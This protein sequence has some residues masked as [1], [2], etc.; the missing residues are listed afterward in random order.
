MTWVAVVLIGLGVADLV[1]TSL[2]RRRRLA[3]H[4]IGP[5]VV[6]AVALLSGV[7]GWAD[8]IA[9]LLALGG[10][11][12]WTELS[13]R[14]QTTGRPAIWAL[15]ALGGTLAGLLAFSG[16]TTRPNGP[17]ESWL[18]W[19]DLPGS[20]PPDSGRV[21]LLTGLVLFNLATAN[22]VVRLVLL[23]IGALRP[24]Q[25]TL[26]RQPQAAD[27]LKGGRLLGPMERLVI[28]GL[29]LAGEFGAA[30]LVIA[31]KG[32]LRFPE[33]QA[34]AR[35][36]AA[37]LRASGTAGSANPALPSGT[38]AGTRTGPAGID[39]VTEYFLV[40]SFVSWLLALGSLAVAR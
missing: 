14:A 3:A 22:I 31:A 27:R 39:D 28:L 32:L 29:G 36:S 12:L 9:L 24:D 6:L 17:L 15:T 18:G 33:I 1:R 34:S 23:A 11:A 5:V 10:C 16:A 35:G 2:S 4:L 25:L 30:G 21:L 26:P 38:T 19:A 7:S 37:S 40:G 8:A 13:D 20:G